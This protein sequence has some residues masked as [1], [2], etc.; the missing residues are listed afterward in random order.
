MEFCKEDD[1]KIRFDKICGDDIPCTFEFVVKYKVN[2]PTSFPYEKDDFVS[3]IEEICENGGL[4]RGGPEE[5]EDA[6]YWINS[7]FEI[8]DICVDYVTTKIKN[9]NKFVFK[10]KPKFYALSPKIHPCIG[11]YKGNPCPYRDVLGLCRMHY[12]DNPELRTHPTILKRIEEFN[13]IET[14]H[15]EYARMINKKYE[16]MILRPPKGEKN[17]CKLTVFDNEMGEIWYEDKSKNPITIRY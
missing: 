12:D 5:M 15:Q 14:K 7:F 17:I 3:E 13:K 11:E 9:K 6:F 1:N 16:N 4:G 8:Q 10:F 2:L